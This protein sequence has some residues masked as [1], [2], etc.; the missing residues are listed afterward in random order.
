MELLDLMKLDMANF[1]IQRIRPQIQQKSVE[2]E[3]EKF[4][5]F[6]DTQKSKR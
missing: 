4:K 1:H 3:R 5:D 6:L 2:Q